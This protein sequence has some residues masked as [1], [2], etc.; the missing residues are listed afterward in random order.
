MCVLTLFC[1]VC[2]CECVYQT[3]PEIIL[4]SALLCSDVSDDHTPR[5][6]TTDEAAALIL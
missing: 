3:P 4:R 6:Q 1:G 2:V 5:S